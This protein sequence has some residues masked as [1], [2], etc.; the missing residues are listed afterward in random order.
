MRVSPKAIKAELDKFVAGQEALKKVM[1]IVGYNHYLRHYGGAMQIATPDPLN[2]IPLILGPTGTGKTLTANILATTCLG[3]PF[4]PIDATTIAQT[5][6]HGQSFDEQME[7][8][9]KKYKGTYLANYLEHTIV[10]IDEFDKIC[11]SNVSSGGTNVDAEIQSNLLTPFEG[12]MLD[13]GIKTDKMLFILSGSFT[14]LS[15][16]LKKG[17][18]VGFKADLTDKKEFKTP[19]LKELQNYGMLAEII[20]RIGPVVSTQKLTRE[21]V[22]HALNDVG[23]SLLSRFQA[24][25]LLSGKSL[26]IPDAEMDQIVD[27]IYENEYGMRYAKSIL[28]EHLKEKM[29]DLSTEVWDDKS[30][31]ITPAEET[32]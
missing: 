27:K 4:V 11:G 9:F 6:W 19:T 1:A 21:E 29:F 7:N 18:P 14:E 3:Y 10:F 22:K 16:N 23:N 26:N 20:G 12:R 8:A 13:C 15:E 30:N 5:G 17:G 24:T 28:F 25:F 32:Y 2:F 31:I